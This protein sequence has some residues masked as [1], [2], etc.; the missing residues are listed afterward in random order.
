MSSALTF[1]RPL[2][3]WL[4]LPLLPGL[5]AVGRRSR[6]SLGTQSRRLA[7]VVRSVVVTLLV[8]A[9]AGAHLIKR[10]DRL[11]TIFLLDVSRSI[12]PDQR[13]QGLAY[14]QRALAA[15]GRDDQAGVVVFGRTAFLEDAPADTL[16]QLDGIHA[17]VAGD[18]TDLAAA[19]RLAASA[20]PTDTGRKIVVLSDGNENRG[21]AAEAE[22]LRASGVRVDVA[23]SALGDAPQGAA[24]PEAL[25]ENLDLPPHVPASAPFALRVVVSSTAPQ[26]ASVAI[27]QDGRL[28]DRRTV[29][30]HA[31]KNAVVFPEKIAAA[32]FHRYDAALTPTTDGIAENNQ[33][34]GFVSV[35]GRPRVLYV[36]DG[37]AAASD[38]PRALSG[39]GIDLQM[40]AP[41]AVPASLSQIASYDAVLVSDVPAG[42]LS[43]AQMTALAAA[44]REFGVGLGMIGGPHSFGA[45]GYSGTPLE[46]ALP[47]RMDVRSSRRLPAAAIVVVLD[48]SGSM[49]A[50]EDGVEKV[51]LGARAAVRLMGALQPDDQVAVNA[52]TTS[53]SVVV[54]LQPASKAGAAK[55]A[56]EGVEAGGGGIYCRQGLSDAYAMLL[57]SHA[58]IR[59]VILCA[60]TTDSEQQEDC[61]AM[62]QDMAR[63]HHITLTVCGI[64]HGGDPHV[65]FQRALAKAGGGQ[66]FIVNEAA[67]LPGLFQRDVQTIQQSWFVEKPFLPRSDPSD[68]VLAGVPFAAAPPLLGYDL[69]TPKP[70]AAVALSAPGQGDPVFAHW[71]YGLGRAF[72]FTSD[73]RAHWAVHWLPWPGYGRFWAQAVRWSLRSQSATD[74]QTTVSDEQGRAHIVVDAYNAGGGFADRSP[75]S[76][77]V[78]AP[79]LT[80]QTVLLSQTAPG[81]YEGTFDADQTGAYMVNVRQGGA[82]ASSQTV[83][84]VVPYS[85]EY[86]TLGPNLPLLTQLADGT[87]GKIQPDPTKVF[88][89]SAIW[90]AGIIDLAPALLLL[91]ALLFL[92]DIAVRRLAPTSAPVRQAV[93]RAA[94]NVRGRVAAARTAPTS[95][96][97]AVTEPQARQL[98]DRRIAA[99]APVPDDRPAASAANPLSRRAA[100][101]DDDD[102][103][104]QVASLY[105]KPAPR[106]PTPAPPTE[107]DY[108][109]RLEAARRRA[110]QRDD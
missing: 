91:T 85:P 33:G 46:T 73:D 71:R 52:V 50:T 8:L 55:A 17:S 89:D 65:P 31:G 28:A 107:A 61:V 3:L 80:A 101:P 26:R 20:F 47:V 102:P 78:V 97:S 44:A 58:P 18:A 56:I 74:F 37:G 103:F 105:G 54:P 99:R 62:A 93:T 29:M 77:H 4:L 19:L 84:Y 82:S 76:S 14:I 15:K 40:V 108:A 98:L 86:R 13:A 79:D 23:P 48:A 24:S 27:R 70:G 30:L 51:Q 34:Y 69:S 42:E 35:T 66:L 45:G 49:A 96:A 88:R 106:P 36:T 1:D 100:A 12:R 6:V 2:L 87:G 59:H 95:P 16:Q 7:L 94:Q 68:A 41:G 11:T 83:G 60:D 90:V 53:T 39:P 21:D 64:G 32:G 38:L 81:R 57:A 72:A 67:D 109:D 104:P 63:R 5:W 110:R 10:S 25:V 22:T 92:A 43:P 9:L 75:L